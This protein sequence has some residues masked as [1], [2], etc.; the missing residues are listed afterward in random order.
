M[1]RKLLA[2]HIFT[3]RRTNYERF[4]DEQ[5][6]VRRDFDR[7]SAPDADQKDIEFTLE[8]YEKYIEYHFEPY[9]AMHASRP[10]SNLWGKDVLWG[11]EALMTDHIGYYSKDVKAFGQPTAANYHEEYPHMV[12]AYVY[13]HQYLDSEFDYEDLEQKYLAQE[14]QSSETSAELK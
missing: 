11:D 7:I 12:S 2:Q 3:I 1:I 8:K 14:A 13:S 5:Y 10:H 9:V 6:K 4:Y